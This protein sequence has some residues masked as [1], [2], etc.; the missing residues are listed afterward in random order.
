MGLDMYLNRVNNNENNGGN[1]IYYWRKCNHIHDWF[2]RNGNLNDNFN[3]GD[4]P[5][6]INKD[7]AQKLIDELKIV[8]ENHDKA[9]EL[10]PTASGFFWGNTDYDEWY[11]K[12][13]QE[14]RVTLITEFLNTDWDNEHWE[15]SCWW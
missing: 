7:L 3:A 6:T 14:T 10:F 8:I 11:Y 2:I 15:Y 13:L 5:L 12:S 4:S 1:E 9:A